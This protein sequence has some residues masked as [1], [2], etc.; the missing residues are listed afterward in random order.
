MGFLVYEDETLEDL[1]LNN[2]Y[3]IQK[4]E[5]SFRFGMDAVILAGFAKAGPG[6]T[7]VDLGT[8]TGIIAI[9]M[10][11]KT[12]ADKIIGIEIQPDIADMARRSVEGNGLASRVSIEVMDIKEAASRLPAGRIDVVVA[13]PPYTKCGGGL[14]NPSESRAISRHEILCTLGDV[15][16]AASML[17]RNHGEFYM[18]HRPD[19]LCDIM[20][21]MRKNRLEPKELRLVCPRV[22]EAPS[23]VLVRGKRN[24]NPGMKL[25]APL[26]IYDSDGSYTSEVRSIYGLMGNHQASDDAG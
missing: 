16:K 17:L 14:V 20:V 9:L 10:S 12:K 2:L 21:E 8:G 19:R 26:Y 11:A 23:L 1:Q 13:N 7:V 22:G 15:V 24:G 25:L 18:V 6:D 4:K 3:I 5:S